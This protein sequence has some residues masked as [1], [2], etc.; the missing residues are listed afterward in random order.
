MSL[1]R[2]LAASRFATLIV[3]FGTLVGSI[4]LLV[5]EAI[6]IVTVV[7]DAAETYAM[8]PKIAK[9]LAVGLIEAIDVFLIAIVAQIIGLGVY[10]LFIDDTLPLLRWLKIRNLDDLK[11]HLVSNVIA[12]LAVLFLREAVGWD[13]Q[14]DLLGFGASLAM[15]IAVLTLYLAVKGMG[16][17][18]AK[19]EARDT[20][21]G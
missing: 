12:V 18:K 7:I 5:Y 17:G 6:V 11:N 3:V 13:G 20:D 1:K 9:V 2:L 8:S 4:A 14:R 10:V 19:E 21:Q 15:V 16:K